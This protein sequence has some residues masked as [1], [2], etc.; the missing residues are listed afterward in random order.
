MDG[1]AIRDI[2][3]DLFALVPKRTRKRR[4]VCEAMAE[5]RWIADI[6]GALS[7]LAL[8]QY[9]QLWIALREVHL[10][11]TPDRLLWRWTADAQYSSKSCYEVLF[12]GS[13]LSSSWEINWRTWAPPRVKFFIWLA[14]QDR[15]WTGERLARRGLQ[16]PPRCPLCDQAGETMGHLL[17]GCPFAR[18]IWHEVLS[19]IRSTAGPPDGEDD[20]VDWWKS[21]LRSTPRAMR[22]GTSSLVMLT[23]WWIWKHRNAIIFDDANPDLGHLLDTIRSE[24]RSWA[25][26]GAIGLGALIP[27]A[28]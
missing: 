15:C 1:H 10:T 7:P 2:A 24:A 6:Q 5:R 20:F 16:H 11:L 8:C 3:P 22:K 9:V 27:A 25:L 21:A 4:T 23:A 28:A 17:T 14:C 18:T 12:Q 13:L 26:A 19:W